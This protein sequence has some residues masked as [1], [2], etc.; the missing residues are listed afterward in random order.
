MNANR[1]ALD[2]KILR[3]CKMIRNTQRRQAINTR[4]LVDTQLAA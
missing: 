4:S 1:A 3:E 2:G